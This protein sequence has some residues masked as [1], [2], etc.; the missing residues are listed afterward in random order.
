MQW[1]LGWLDYKTRQAK[2]SIEPERE[3][4]LTNSPPEC[5]ISDGLLM[6]LGSV[7][8]VDVQLLK[9]FM[10]RITCLGSHD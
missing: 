3:V 7:D 5:V 9:S 6:R 8:V 1:I 4:Y 10:D 2:S